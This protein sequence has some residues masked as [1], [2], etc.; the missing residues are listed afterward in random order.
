MIRAVIFDMYETLITHYRCPLYFG[1]Q[2]AKDAGVS[3]DKFQATWHATNDERTTGKMTFEEVIERILKENECYSEDLLEE[4]VEKRVKTKEECFRHLH[5]EIIPMLAKLKEKGIAVGLISNCFSEEVAPIRESELAPYFDAM[6]L[7]YEQG[8][9]K[10]EPEIFQSCMN[11]L[12]VKA[13][14]CLYIGDG[15]SQ[16]LEAARSLGM[17]ALQAT[18]YFQEGTFQPCGP[19]EDFQQLVT[20][21]DVVNLLFGSCGGSS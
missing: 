1:V 5:P 6:C 3:E 9:Q 10:P 17:N 14:E 15:G 13:E 11:L 18:W 12:S 8:V 2:M 4:I 19:K 20:P 16:E 21:M 7:S